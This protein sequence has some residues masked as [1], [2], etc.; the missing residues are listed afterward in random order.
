MT[1]NRTLQ[2]T[3]GLAAA[4]GAA[5]L[6]KIA[7]IAA[8]DGAAAGTA[9]AVAAVLYLLGVALLVVGALAVTLRLARGR[10]RAA[11]AAAVVAAP[12]LAV[13]SFV[14]LDGVAQALVGDTDPVWVG[15]EVGIL[16]TG[17]VWLAVGVAA[18]RA[19]RPAQSA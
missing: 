4:G 14:V 11:L 18:L 2:I 6:T 8:T 10:G 1:S 3:A 13:A 7:V 15:E 16:A 5:W 19:A 12:I 9:E 17:A